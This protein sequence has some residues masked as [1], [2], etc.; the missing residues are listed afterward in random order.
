MIKRQCPICGTTYEADPARLKHGRQTTCS[1]SCSYFLRASTRSTSITGPCTVCG[2][3]VTRPPSK[4]ARSK[5]TALLCSPKCAYQ[6][7]SLGLVNRTVVHP[8]K[9]PNPTREKMAQR[10]RMKNKKRKKEGRYGHTEETKAKISISVAKAISEGR[11]PRVSKIEQQVAP[12]LDKLGIT[13][14]T[15]YR[16]RGAKGQFAAVVDYFLPNLNTALEFNG[17]FWHSDPRVYPNG[18]QHASQ[19]RTAEKYMRKLACLAARG[20]SVVEVWE[21]DFK[22]DPE[23]SVKAALNP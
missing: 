22:T 11:F 5:T 17:T 18:P 14:Q 15:Q 4:T 1:R 21:M 12:I 13:Y 3:P 19:K 8:Y 9:I 10:M 16:V 6:A 20:I 23:G 7:R 2:T